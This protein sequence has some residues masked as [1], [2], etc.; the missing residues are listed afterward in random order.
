MITFKHVSTRAKLSA[1]FVEARLNNMSPEEA[2]EALAHQLLLC[3]SDD[4]AALLLR[5]ANEYYLNETKQN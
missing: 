1:A 5:A 2:G 4:D 3:Y